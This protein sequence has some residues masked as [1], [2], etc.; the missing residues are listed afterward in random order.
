MKVKLN[1]TPAKM[2]IHET[3]KDSYTSDRN[4]LYH[5]HRMNRNASGHGFHSDFTE[6]GTQSRWRVIGFRPSAGI[7]F[8]GGRCSR[9]PSRGHRVQNCD[10]CSLVVRAAFRPWSVWSSQISINSPADKRNIIT[11]WTK[12]YIMAFG[13]M[14]IMVRFTMLKYEVMR[15]SVA[16]S[17]SIPRQRAR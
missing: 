2:K 17:V 4:H 3:G 15:S 14:S 1:S 12:L 13:T 9:S 16:M 8:V 6:P 7:P 11:Y 5:Y 10:T